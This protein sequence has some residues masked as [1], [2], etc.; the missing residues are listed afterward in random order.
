AAMGTFGTIFDIG[1]ASG[2]IVT[3][4]LVASLGYGPAYISV[5]SLLIFSVPMFLATVREEPE[6]RDF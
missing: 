1:H 4:L 5:A 3:G 2:P 6:S